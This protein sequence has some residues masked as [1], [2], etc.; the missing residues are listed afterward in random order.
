MT[1]GALFSLGLDAGGTQT[2]WALCREDGAVAATG[3][4]GGLSALQLNDAAGREAVAQVLAELVLQLAPVGLP[5]SAC[6]GVTG[7][8]AAHEPAALA[9]RAMLCEALA[10]KPERVQLCSDIELAYRSAFP[11]GAGHLV[12]AGTGSVGATLDES[13]VLQRVGG[14]GGILDD[15]GGGF[16]IA[17]EA[18]NQIWRAEDLRPG[19]WRDS[20]MAVAVLERVGSSEWAATRHFVYA[21]SRGAMGELAV[22][23]AAS[24]NADP[25]ALMLLRQAGVELARLALALLARFGARPVALAG[26]AAQLHPVIFQSFR[27]ALPAELEVTPIS[28][29]GHVGAA[30]LASSSLA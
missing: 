12:Y 18:L 14:R 4:V 10:L 8:G 6:A 7:L 9:L 30:R 19:A 22:A 20:P 28:I 1:G 11:S 29:E 17:R 2:R 13:G 26:R 25:R 24:A 15:A 21:G 5:G 23:V 16:W 3:A 27:A